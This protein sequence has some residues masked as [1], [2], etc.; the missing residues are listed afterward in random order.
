MI[1][2]EKVTVDDNFWLVQWDD[3]NEAEQTQRAETLLELT[4]SGF[5]VNVEPHPVV[6]P[7]DEPATGWADLL[8]IV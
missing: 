6:G 1:V 2:C 8:E 3:Q 7:G 5:T 4:E